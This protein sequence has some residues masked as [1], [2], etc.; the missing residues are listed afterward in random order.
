MGHLDEGDL[1][2]L[3]GYVLA[4]RAFDN[5]TLPIEINSL[6]AANGVSDFYQS[7]PPII[8]AALEDHKIDGYKLIDLI[9]VKKP[10]KD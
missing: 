6:E 5:P 10:P 1:E 9:Q 4:I 2:R 7:T 3:L 8:L